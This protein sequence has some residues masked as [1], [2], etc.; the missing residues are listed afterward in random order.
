MEELLNREELPSWFEYPE[1]LRDLVRAKS[2]DF[3][4]W[5][6]LLGKWLGVRLQGLRQ[7]YPKR[8]LVPFARRVDSD[9]V[10]CFD[11]KEPV[12]RVGVVII[13]DFASPGWELRGEFE[14]FEQW[15]DSAKA[16]ARDWR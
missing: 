12:E 3:G 9:D 1:T 13:H 4:P 5:Q 6:I 15:L 10:A 14:D 11:V 2:I 8:H 7:R 16:D